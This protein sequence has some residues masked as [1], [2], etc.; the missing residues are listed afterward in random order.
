MW[1]IRIVVRRVVVVVS[2]CDGVYVSGCGVGLKV[3][4]LV[5]CGGWCGWVVVMVVVWCRWCGDCGGSSVM[6]VL[7]LVLR[8]VV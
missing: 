3:V 6:R 1:F 4:V 8:S 7:G 2:G 5:V